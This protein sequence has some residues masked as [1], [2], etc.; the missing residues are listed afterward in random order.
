MLIDAHICIIIYTCMYILYTFMNTSAHAFTHTYTTF[1]VKVIS[2]YI[3][4]Q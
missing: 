3:V 4:C 2:V 1:T